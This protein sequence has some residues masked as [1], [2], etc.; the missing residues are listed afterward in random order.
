MAEAHLSLERFCEVLLQRCAGI[1]IYL[2]YVLSEVER[3]ERSPLD[4]EDLPKGVWQ[5]YAR[6]WQRWRTRHSGDWDSLHLPLLATL[7]AVDEGPLAFICDLAGVIDSNSPRRLFE[8]SWSPFVAISGG[9]TRSYRLYH[10]SLRE[11][12]SGQADLSELIA[13]EQA[14]AEELARATEKAHSSIADRYLDAWGGLQDGLPK[15]IERA[16]MDNS[17]GFRTVVAHLVGARRRDDF[18]RLLRLER[19]AANAA[20]NTWY[21]ARDRE[22]DVGGYLA[23]LARVHRAAQEACEEQIRDGHPATIAR[24][25]QYALM[26]ASIR[27]LGTK[28]SLPLLTAL[29]E[30]GVWSPIKTLAYARNLSSPKDRSLSERF[31]E[32]K[33]AIL[34][35][36]REV[37]RTCDSMDCAEAIAALS[38]HLPD[39][40]KKE[41]LSEALSQ[42]FI[43]QHKHFSEAERARILSLL[44]PQLPP[45]LLRG[46][47]E[48]TRGLEDLEVKGKTL[49]ALAPSLPD[50]WRSDALAALGG[51]SDVYYWCKAVEGLFPYL[52]EHLRLDAWHK[53]SASRQNNETQ[54]LHCVARLWRWLPEPVCLDALRHARR[55]RDPRLLEAMLPHA[56]PALK[57]ELAREAVSAA[58][59][60]PRRSGREALIRAAG[61]VWLKL[62]GLTSKRP[63]QQKLLSALGN[64]SAFSPRSY[65]SDER[66]RVEIVA[67]ALPHVRGAFARTGTILTGLR[68]LRRLRKSDWK[69]DLDVASGLS[70]LAES[71]PA[72]LLGLV[73]RLTAG[74][75]NRSQRA[76]IV[77]Q[78]ACRLP[79]PE[80][81]KMLARA[82]DMVRQLDNSWERSEGLLDLSTHLNGDLRAKVLAEA[83]SAQPISDEQEIADTL[84]R[85]AP[86]MPSP[87]REIALRGALAAA[88]ERGPFNRSGLQYL[89]PHLPQELVSEALD[90][91]KTPT[92]SFDRD[93]K[94]Q[95]ELLKALVPH[96]PEE[97]LPEALKTAKSQSYKD[98]TQQWELL[99]ACIPYLPPNLV[100][101]AL[102][103]FRNK[104]KAEVAIIA[105]RSRLSAAEKESLVQSAYADIRSRWPD[106]FTDD[107]VALA[108]HLPPSFPMNSIDLR[109]KRS[110]K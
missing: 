91:V 85:L 16:L 95:T 2:Y 22:G 59:R 57:A 101:D 11:F 99:E 80:K 18:D 33:A 23:D 87:Q 19:A 81:T 65:N 12:L 14:F 104:T 34:R 60:L 58:R 94:E 47:F 30:H 62:F 39:G 53:L 43:V 1:W 89:F 105:L 102:A 5:Y 15:L 40:Q 98:L 6:F 44:A 76:K 49:A 90:V 77:A 63:W 45:K 66:G 72:P 28:L 84:G 78:C 4:L 21:E 86:G 96:L 17:Y 88:R 27:S 3:G 29:L 106:D 82:L 38:T 103:A 55:M 24:E 20:T 107:L 108:P 41:V 36:S 56:P 51:P 100:H 10:A 68:A 31:P 46:A 74:V 75:E 50:E 26:S 92:Y 110:Q 32:Q 35:E 109:R 67:A 73:V 64:R 25:I 83:A 61:I 8:E 97:L 13:V 52:P 70:R 54:Y 9:R 7:A 37:A 42:W 71:L 48:V 69:N 79:E 93:Q